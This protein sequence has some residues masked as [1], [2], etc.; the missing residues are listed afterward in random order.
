MNNELTVH[1]TQQVTA[2]V[3]EPSKFNYFS[4]L[5]EYHQ[6]P[7][8]YD[9]ATF[10][11]S[12]VKLNKVPAPPY[13]NFSIKAILINALCRTPLPWNTRKASL[14]RYRDT[15]I[16]VF[17]GVSKT[18]DPIHTVTEMIIAFY[19]AQAENERIKLDDT[20]TFTLALI[21]SYCV[22]QQL[23][24]LKAQHITNLKDICDLSGDYSDAQRHFDTQKLI[25]SLEPINVTDSYAHKMLYNAYNSIRESLNLPAA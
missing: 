4:Y 5:K 23:K 6:I 20:D 7:Q 19:K 11:N 9:V 12:A 18:I 1:S 10:V 25:D 8:N 21:T 16:P 15:D 17:K 14:V 13:S 2:E 24:N 22:E 3:I